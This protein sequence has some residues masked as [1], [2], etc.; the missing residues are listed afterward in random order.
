M[1]PAITLE[2]L[3]AWNDEAATFW[4]RHLDAHPPLLEMPCGIG[5]AATVQVFV[6]HI[7]GV[8]LRWAQI[9]AGL[10]VTSG[11]G[12]P[13]GPLIALFGIHVLATDIY[14]SLFDRPREFWD[15]KLA[16]EYDW[17][18]A[19][20]RNASRRKLAAHGLFHGQ[21]HWAQLATLVRA[22]GSPSQFKGDLLFSPA[23]P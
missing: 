7:W 8:E 10:P 19:H 15:E 6:R 23:L 11:R 21:R 12:L 17:L 18:P 5:G 4:N 14:R 22:A 9:V 13:E 16:L 3:L 2:E 1:T 20:L